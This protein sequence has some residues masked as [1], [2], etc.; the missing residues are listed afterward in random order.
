[1]NVTLT[2][3][4]QNHNTWTPSHN[5]NC[6][7]NP[8]IHPEHTLKRTRA[9]QNALTSDRNDLACE[10]NGQLTWG[11]EEDEEQEGQGW[12][13]CNTCE[14]G[15][16]KMHGF[17]R[18]GSNSLSTPSYSPFTPPG[19][20]YTPTG[21]REEEGDMSCERPAKRQKGEEA[22]QAEKRGHSMDISMLG[23]DGDSD[24]GEPQ[25]SNG[26]N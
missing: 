9:I 7:H 14:P 18:S 13:P 24:S 26:L 8:Y 17:I 5:D 23:N 12:G 15:S 10:P 19:S 6:Q 22:Q 25:D 11:K 4:S 21:H 20:P 2:A 3:H 1:M 16:R